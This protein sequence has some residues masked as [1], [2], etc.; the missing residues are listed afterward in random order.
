MHNRARTDE[1]DRRPARTGLVA[2]GPR[3]VAI[4][5]CAGIPLSAALLSSVAEGAVLGVG[6]SV[7]ALVAATLLV[8]RAQRHRAHVNRSFD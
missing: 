1:G 5:C 7:A 8:V 4:A 3:A 6:A 2:V